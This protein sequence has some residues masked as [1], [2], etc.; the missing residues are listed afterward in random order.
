MNQRRNLFNVQLPILWSTALLAWVNL[1][2]YVAQP[3]DVYMP[4]PSATV[5]AIG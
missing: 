5:A 3:T 1:A 2:E 4:A